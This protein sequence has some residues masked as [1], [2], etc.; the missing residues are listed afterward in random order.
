MTGTIL[1]FFFFGCMLLACCVMAYKSG[2]NHE[3]NVT[4][5]ELSRRARK[6]A[7]TRNRLR[8]DA[9]YARRVRQQFTR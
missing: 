6:G 1:L 5:K 9:A 4:Q 3:K 7:V 2:A 8:R